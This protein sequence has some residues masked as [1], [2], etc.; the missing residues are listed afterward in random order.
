MTHEARKFATVDDV[1]NGYVSGQCDVLT[2]DISQLYA[3][4]IEA[5][6]AGGA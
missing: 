1:F 2:A 3:A 5:L 4:A 6:Q